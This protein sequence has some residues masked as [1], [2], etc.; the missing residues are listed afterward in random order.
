MNDQNKL[1]DSRI[2]NDLIHA[3]VKLNTLLF[4]C[5]LA[6]IFG[7][8]LFS[9]TYISMYRTPEGYH[10]FLNLLGVFLPGYTVSASGAW[11]GLLWGALVGAITGIVIYR[12]YAR[13]IY[14]QVLNFLESPDMKESD[15]DR[16][17]LKIEGHPLGIA[18]GSFVAI[19]LILSTNLLVIRGAAENSHHAG[20]LSHYLPGYSVSFMGSIIGAVELFIFTYI[21]C[22]ILSCVY[23]GVVSFS[24]GRNK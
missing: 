8:G 4:A 13:S 11:I 1:N 2:D 12:I 6:C 9:L 10:N 7:I 19:S 14:S 3:T 21:L 22:Q 23:N 17:T 5:V 16:V 18:L 20:L 15:I 24:E